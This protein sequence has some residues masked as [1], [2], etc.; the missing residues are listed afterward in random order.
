MSDRDDETTERKDAAAGGPGGEPPRAPEHDQDAAAGAGGSG[1]AIPLAALGTEELLVSFL[2]VLA[3][4]AWEGM[5]LVAAMGT[6]TVAKDLGSA[7]LAIDAYSAVFDLV[8]GRLQDAQRREMET[9]L[10]NLR[11]NFVD[12]SAG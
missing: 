2:G 1:R 9:L 10:M 5:G 3:A 7:R 4:K 6:G 8:R 11:V 12:K